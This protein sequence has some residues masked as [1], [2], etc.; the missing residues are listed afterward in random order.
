MEYFIRYIIFELIIR[1]DIILDRDTL[2]INKNPICMPLNYLLMPL[3][4][5]SE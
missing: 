4:S 3:I 1:K 2:V 5:F